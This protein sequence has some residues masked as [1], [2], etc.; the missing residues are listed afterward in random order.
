MKRKSLEQIQTKRTFFKKLLDDKT[1]INIL[2]N[3]GKY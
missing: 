2:Q 3:T 1:I